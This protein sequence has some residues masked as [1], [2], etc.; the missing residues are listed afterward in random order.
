MVILWVLW[1]C[2]GGKAMQEYCAIHGGK[3]WNNFTI[4][5][6]QYWI[7]EKDQ[8]LPLQRVMMCGMCAKL[9]PT[10]I[11]KMQGN[12][13]KNT[14]SWFI[15]TTGWPF[16]NDQKGHWC[17]HWPLKRP[18]RVITTHWSQCTNFV[19][20]NESKVIRLL[21]GLIVWNSNESAR[22]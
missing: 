13:V 2:G 5:F 8:T 18:L 17:R 12:I 4:I 20:K 21:N 9:R 14:L 15:A 10:A 22:F 1:M 16:I 11:C 19:L 3:L 6:L 7:Y